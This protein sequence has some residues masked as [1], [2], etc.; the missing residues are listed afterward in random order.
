T[1]E[2]KISQEKIEVK[3]RTLTFTSVV[4]NLVI[5]IGVVVALLIVADELGI[6]IAPVLAGAGIAGI[7]V[8]LGAQ[9]LIK[10]LINGT[11]ILFEQWF[12]VNDIVTI[13]D[14][15]GVVEKFSLRTTVLRDLEGVVHYIPNGEIK[16]LSNRT[17]QWARA[18]VDVA[19]HYKED[20]DRVINV[21]ESIFDEFMEDERYK[22]FIIERPVILGDGGVDSLGDSAVVFKV[23][24]TVKPPNQWTIARQLRKRIKDRF[25]KEG[26]EIPFPCRSVYIK[27]NLE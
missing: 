19:V 14:V 6:Q 13:G 24:C 7:I 25:D 15:S 17:Q 11:F 16:I 2:K 27:E 20:T 3:K 12:Q 4:S 10:D 18:V 21:L 22:K 5:L 1:L 26:I 9:S 23:V 8:G